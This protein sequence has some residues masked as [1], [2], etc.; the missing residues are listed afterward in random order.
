MYL[1]VDHFPSTCK[2]L[3]LTSYNANEK[4]EKFNAVASI[5]INI[6]KNPLGVR[7]SAMREEAEPRRW[8]KA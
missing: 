3:D 1:N 4:K 2:I 6:H 8:R 7:D 5:L